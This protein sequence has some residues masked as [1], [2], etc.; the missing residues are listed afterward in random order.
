MPNPEGATAPA[1]LTYEGTTLELPVV[2]P[3]LGRTALDISAIGLKGLSVLDP[4]Y[5]D[6]AAYQSAITFVDGEEGRLYYRGYPVEQ[7]ATSTSFLDVAYLL[8][9]GELPT[10]QAADEFT[11]RVRDPKMPPRP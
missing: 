4:G 3:T 1:T 8:I 2:R 6:T 7:L 9:N 11:G 10:A 5:A